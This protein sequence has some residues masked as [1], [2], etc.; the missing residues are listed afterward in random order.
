MTIFDYLV[1]LVLG[2]SVVISLMRGLVR[3]V[4]SLVGW[5]AAFVVANAYAATLGQMLP[6]AVPGEVLRLILAFIALFIATRLLTGLLAKALSAVLE[7]GGLSWAD[8]LLGVV[9]GMLRGLLIVLT[10][11]ILAGMTS[12]PQQAFWREARL[13]PYAE[14]LAHSVKPL[15][16][17]ALAQ[18]VNF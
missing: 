2:A 11:V 16:P 14:T 12:L 7:A 3:E 6:P 1:L 13:S 8:R 15:L 17:A 9:F 5:V 10:V 4:L 18:H